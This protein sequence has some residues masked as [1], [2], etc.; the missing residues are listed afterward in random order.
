M[1]GPKR[2]PS[3]VVCFSGNG[4]G[5]NH[6][7]KVGPMNGTAR[8]RA[9]IS[10]FP[11]RKPFLLPRRPSKETA[12]FRRGGGNVM[13][14]PVSCAETFMPPHRRLS[15]P[16]IPDRF[17]FQVNSDPTRHIPPFP[18]TVADLGSE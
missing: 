6:I 11:N 18:P 14:C 1:K 7:W 10:P 9:G 13:S 16:L 4:P 8:D 15:D 2:M 12:H 5:G 3:M 17:S